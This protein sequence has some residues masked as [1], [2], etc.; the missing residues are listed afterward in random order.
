MGRRLRLAV[1]YR[2]RRS[3]YWTFTTAVSKPDVIISREDSPGAAHLSL[4]SDRRWH[5]SVEG[6]YYEL[7]V[8]TAIE[9]IGVRPA[10]TVIVSPTACVHPI[11]DDLKADTLVLPSERAMSMSIE[12]FL[13]GN[14][15]H[16]V[17]RSETGAIEPSWTLPLPD[18]LS[19]QLIARLVEPSPLGFEVDAP[20]EDVAGLELT[21][22]RGTADHWLVFG[23]EHGGPVTIID[24][25]IER[26]LRA[27]EPS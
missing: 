13:L 15:G 21:P 14:G 18:G 23:S 20:A 9:P 2:E 8:A 6:T 10:V 7:P 3:L 11:S 16:I 5:L 22:E 4:H 12:L 25:T 24:A 19:A 26:G 27:Q 1:E 17:C